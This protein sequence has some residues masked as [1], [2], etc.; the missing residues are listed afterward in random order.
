VDG[1]EDPA[2][3]LGNASSRTGCGRHA[4]DSDDPPNFSAGEPGA[5]RVDI[6]RYPNAAKTLK[7]VISTLGG[8][9]KRDG[10]Q[11]LAAAKNANKKARLVPYIISRDTAYMLEIGDLYFRVFKSDGTQ[12]AGPYEVVTPYTEAY[13]ADMDY[14]KSDDAMF[15]F[16]SA[17]YPNRLRTFADKDCS[18]APHHAF[19]DR[20]VLAVALTLNNTVGTGRTMT[21]ALPCSSDVGAILWNAGA[22]VS[23]AFTSTTIVTVEVKII[24]DRHPFR[25]VES[26]QQPP[27]HADASEK[28]RLARSSP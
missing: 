11:Y 24:F 10:T 4:E 8:V 26:R 9:K 21:A 14:A 6:A 25:F 27:D 2:E 20:G 15:L 7:N 16:H 22:A 1:Q 5:G 13:V 18:A 23:P 3:T 12:V 19:A 17:V 28:T